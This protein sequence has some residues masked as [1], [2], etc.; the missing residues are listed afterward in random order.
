MS[1][2]I[3]VVGEHG[4]TQIDENNFNFSCV[5]KGTVNMPAATV[6][7]NGLWAMASVTLTL[8]GTFPLLFINPKNTAAAVARVTSSGTTHTFTIRGGLN[9]VGQP[10]ADSFSWF[11]FDWPPAPGLHGA[12]F[13]VFNGNGQCTFDSDYPPMRIA[14]VLQVPT[15]RNDTVLSLPAGDYACCLGQGRLTRTPNPTTGSATLIDVF[16]ITPTEVRLSQKYLLFGGLGNG[17][18]YTNGGGGQALIIDASR[19]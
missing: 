15:N 16:K 14:G 7:S 10:T 6:S 5:A 12:G 17:T 1:A 8:N 2:G 19:L 3:L 4:S 13:Q 9:D 11:L 18:T